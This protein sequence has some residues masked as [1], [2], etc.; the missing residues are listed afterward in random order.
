MQLDYIDS[1][2]L[3]SIEHWKKKRLGYVLMDHTDLLFDRDYFL[4]HYKD[5]SLNQLVFHGNF[6]SEKANSSHLNIGFQ[7]VKKRKF[8]C[9]QPLIFRG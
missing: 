5:G 1:L 9:L 2:F 3:W 8:R 6:H 4:S 7:G